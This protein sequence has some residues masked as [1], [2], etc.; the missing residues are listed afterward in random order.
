M[1]NH[2]RRAGGSETL[3]TSYS[4]GVKYQE[5]LRDYFTTKGKADTDINV[6]I[7]EKE[8]I[9]PE[10]IFKDAS[11][12]YIVKGKDLK[13]AIAREFYDFNF[14]IFKIY[15]FIENE[16]YKNA[17]KIE[18][19][20]IKK[21]LV[22]VYRHY[23]NVDHVISLDNLKEFAATLGSTEGFPFT[24]RALQEYMTN[25]S[26]INFDEIDEVNLE[27]TSQEI[28]EYISDFFIKIKNYF[29]PEVR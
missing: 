5:A 28:Y 19:G 13:E 10:S 16:D 8:S 26:N 12:K 21:F 27:T 20:F 23:F 24:T 14:D 7:L 9:D 6:E 17:L 25:Y 15:N 4:V 18:S 2:P 3:R 1:E 22:N 29:L 11:R